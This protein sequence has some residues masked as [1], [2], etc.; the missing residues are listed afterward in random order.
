MWCPIPPAGRTYLAVASVLPPTQQLALVSFCANLYGVPAPSRRRRHLRRKRQRQRRW[1][2]R[3][4]RR[5]K[6]R[7]R[8]KPPAGL[9]AH[10]GAIP[11]EGHVGRQ[12]EHT[13]QFYREVFR[14]PHHRQR[15]VP[16][17]RAAFSEVARRQDRRYPATHGRQICRRRSGGGSQPL[18]SH[19]QAGKVNPDLS[20]LGTQGLY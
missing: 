17:Q 7:A 4:A 1:M 3:R 15:Q 16:E 13:P 20:L 2:T 6:G 19:L 14:M 11:G 5:R 8:H 9:E 10:R 12:W 18:P